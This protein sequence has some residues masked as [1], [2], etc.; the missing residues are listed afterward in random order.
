MFRDKV[1]S[2][3]QALKQGE[4]VVVADDA[5]REN[6]GDLILA[7]ERATSEAVAFMVRHT[8]G[9]VCAA[10][11][12]ARAE[13]LRL[14]LMVADNAESLR[15]AFTVSVDLKLGTSTGI[16]AADRGATLR[17]LADPIRTAEDFARPGHVFPLRARAGGVLERQG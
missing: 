15:T 17:A 14:P 7:A 10:L 4:F 3:L 6:E 12:D 2:A 9:V 13:A 16:S 1:D 11:T 8:S 5:T